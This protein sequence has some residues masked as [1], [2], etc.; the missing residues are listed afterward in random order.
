MKLKELEKPYKAETHIDH[1][2][3]AQNLITSAIFSGWKIDFEVE[4]NED[5]EAGDAN[6]Y[7]S[8]VKTYVWAPERWDEDYID[9]LH[10]LTWTYPQAVIE[11]AARLKK[12]IKSYN[13]PYCSMLNGVG[14]TWKYG[15]LKKNEC[16][17][18]DNRENSY[19][20]TDYN[21]FLCHNQTGY[22]KI[23]NCPFCGRNLANENS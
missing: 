23:S 3:K 22:I 18:F 20:L 10:L 19:I 8:L 14:K 1:F 17:A 16:I 13:C 4:P 15:Q 11:L 21:D 2:T 9:E 12:T 6:E 5:Y 7:P